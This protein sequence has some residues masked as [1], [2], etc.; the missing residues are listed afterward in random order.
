MTD[1]N[2]KPVFVDPQGDTELVKRMQVVGEGEGRADDFLVV[3]YEP[4]SL[5]HNDVIGSTRDGACGS[6]RKEAVMEFKDRKGNTVELESF[7]KTDPW[8]GAVQAAPGAGMSYLAS[9]INEELLGGGAREAIIDVGLS[10][11]H[12]LKR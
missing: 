9:Q 4:G 8:N 1:D 3:Q 10:S 12:L 11:K 7:G 5:K 6:N 2:N